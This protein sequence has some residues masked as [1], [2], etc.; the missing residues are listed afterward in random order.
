[1]EALISAS[2]H[3]PESNL[4]TD[5]VERLTGRPAGTFARWAADHAAEF[6]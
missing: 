4:I 5:H 2:L 1:M 3:R 6:R